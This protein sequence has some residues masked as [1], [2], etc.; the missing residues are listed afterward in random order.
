MLANKLQNILFYLNCFVISF[1]IKTLNIHSVLNYFKIINIM[2]YK[3]TFMIT[4]YW[5]HL[6]VQVEVFI[7]VNFFNPKKVVYFPITPFK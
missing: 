1:L 7:N 3:I 5:F 6:L 4:C 2:V